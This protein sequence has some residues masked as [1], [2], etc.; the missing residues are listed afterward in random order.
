MGGCR[1]PLR[2]GTDLNSR[3]L[4]DSTVV[5]GLG[6]PI[7]GDDGVGC[8]VAELL[9]TE[10]RRFSNVTVISTFL[11]PIRLV[12]QISGHENLIIIDSVFSQRAEPGTLMR[13]D[14]PFKDGNPLRSHGMSISS[15][16]EVGQAVGLPMPARTVYY[17]IE[18]EPPKVYS[19]SLSPMMESRLPAIV[20]E[21]IEKEFPYEI[22][23]NTKAP[24]GERVI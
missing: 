14:F 3:S 4:P 11:S 1:S 22:E 13:V 5:L 17:G 6:N 12:D 7:L 10:L 2:T 24:R 8:W 21:L 18:I 9:K 20:R 16:N 15:L 23:A 19:S